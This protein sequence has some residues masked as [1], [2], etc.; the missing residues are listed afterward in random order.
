MDNST[1]YIMK[2]CYICGDKLVKKVLE[3]EGEIPYCKKCGTF[4][5]P[6]FST[7][8]SMIIQNPDRNKILLIQQYGKGNNVLVAGYINKGENAESAVIREIKE[9][10]G[11]EVEDVRFNKTEYFEMTNTLMI[12]FSCTAKTEDLSNVNQKEVD[13]AEWFGKDI[14]REV[15]MPNSLAERFLLAFLEVDSKQK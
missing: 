12:N 2:H 3:G 7:A 15:I 6:I 11:I 8:V 14:V 4:R 1:K 13:R 9:E 10:I 5:F